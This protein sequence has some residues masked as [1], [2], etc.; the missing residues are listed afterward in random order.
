MKKF[1]ILVLL[2]LVNATRACDNPQKTVITFPITIS[3]QRGSIK[4]GDDT[5]FDITDKFSCNL[6][7]INWPEKE[8]EHLWRIKD[9]RYQKEGNIEG[10][11]SRCIPVRY[12]DPNTINPYFEKELEKVFAFPSVLPD[13][14]VR[15]LV[16]TGKTILEFEKTTAHFVLQNSEESL[17]KLG[18]IKTPES[19]S[20]SSGSMMF[21]IGGTLVVGIA[22]LIAWF[23]KTDDT[24]PFKAQILSFLQSLMSAK[25]II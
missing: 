11:P 17:T 10:C 23:L 6:L 15:E 20:A 22:G 9:F 24:N 13:P 2:T 4:T 7:G 16:K 12:F 3:E 5:F 21:L 25:S 14:F 8:G 1:F 18:L 19:T